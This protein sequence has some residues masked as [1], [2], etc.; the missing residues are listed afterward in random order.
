MVGDKKR[1]WYFKPKD[2]DGAKAETTDS[3]KRKESAPAKETMVVRLATVRRPPKQNVRVPS[4]VFRKRTTCFCVSGS[5]VELVA[6]QTQTSSSN[7]T[8]PFFASKTDG[9]RSDSKVG[10]TF[11]RPSTHHRLPGASSSSPAPS[12]VARQRFVIP[13]N[14]PTAHLFQMTLV[15]V[16]RTR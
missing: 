6:P 3:C 5:R 1:T 12:V 11:G 13:Q 10:L 8:K 2:V 7:T 15:P 9:C 16:G 4:V 14:P